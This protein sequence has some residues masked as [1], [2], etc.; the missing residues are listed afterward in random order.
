MGALS[1]GVVIGVSIMLPLIYGAI[2][3]F[4]LSVGEM[5]G[6]LSLNW[7]A[8]KEVLMEAFEALDWSNPQQMMGEVFTESYLAD[9][10][11]RCAQAVLGD[12]EAIPAEISELI[13]HAAERIMSALFAGIGFT[14]LGAAIGY[15]VTRMQIRRGMAKR[16]IGKALL[17]SLVD[18]LINATVV[19]V[20]VVLI[21]K[22]RKFA[23]LSVFLTVV[24]YGAVAFFEAYLVHGYKKIPLKQV[25]KI[26]NFFLLFLLMIIELFISL[27]VIL[28]LY[29]FTNA[30]IAFY[31]G[32]SVIIISMTCMSL[33]AEAY[34]KS[35]AESG[36]RETLDESSFA[37]A[38]ESLAPLV[39]H[40]DAESENAPLTE[41]F[42]RSDSEDAHRALSA[43]NDSIP[44]QEETP[45]KEEDEKSETNSVS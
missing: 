6:Q 20:G 29:F 35:L 15:F 44:E 1:L 13:T 23:I 9:L 43:E 27:S 33:N 17:I 12:A 7:S 37:T 22:V 16:K 2:K 34:V 3:D 8:A 36:T 21:L 31:V 24:L 45:L 39:L 25:M 42:A 38:F 18:T 19:A 4:L 41:N 5:L 26:K 11:M 10:L 14:L 30:A 40:A 32:F 28:I